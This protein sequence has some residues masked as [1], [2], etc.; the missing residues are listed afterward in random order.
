MVWCVAFGCSNWDKDRK[1]R[2]VSFHRFPKNPALRKRWVAALKLK[3]VPNP[4]TSYICSE[5]FLES[6]FK[7]DLRAEML[8]P[9]GRKRRELLDGA[10]PSVFCFSDAHVRK[11][12][13]SRREHS[14]VSACRYI[15]L[16]V[17]ACVTIHLFLFAF[18]ERYCRRH[19][20]S[21]THR[22]RA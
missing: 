4:D 1:A 2:S 20:K 18:V 19:W 10:V 21:R 6:D 17:H 14:R 13:T 12:P 22:A 5:H 11:R 15:C 3:D 7:R 9:A 8:G 16:C